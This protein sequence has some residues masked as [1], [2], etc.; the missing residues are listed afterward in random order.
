MYVC[1][2]HTIRICIQTYKRTFLP[3]GF[4]WVFVELSSTGGFLSGG[5]WLDDEIS[6]LPIGARWLLVVSGEMTGWGVMQLCISLVPDWDTLIGDERS[7]WGAPDRS[8]LIGGEIIGWGA[9]HYNSLIAWRRIQWLCIPWLRVPDW[10]YWLV[11][12]LFNTDLTT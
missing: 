11:E 1:C 3:L 6:R 9:P 4:H 12:I 2:M 8:T 10:V 7:G 5:H